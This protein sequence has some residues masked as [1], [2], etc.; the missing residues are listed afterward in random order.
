MTNVAQTLMSVLL[1]LGTAEKI[2]AFDFFTASEGEA[3]ASGVV[4]HAVPSGARRRYRGSSRGESVGGGHIL[5]RR[6][7]PAV[8]TRP[9]PLAREGAL[10]N[11]SPALLRGEAS[12]EADCGREGGHYKM[13][14]P[15]E[16]LQR[17]PPRPLHRRRIPNPARSAGLGLA[18][19]PSRA[20]EYTWRIASFP[21]NL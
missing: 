4:L 10:T 21:H 5:S 12:V 6:G 18:S 19:A 15:R 1:R 16:T 8:R 14:A 11:P 20:A 2:N 17:P 13:L 3:R 9:N 7:R